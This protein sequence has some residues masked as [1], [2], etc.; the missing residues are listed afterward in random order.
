[1]NRMGD[2]AAMPGTA[3]WDAAARAG[4]PRAGRLRGPMERRAAAQQ[5]IDA[6]YQQA[7]VPRVGDYDNPAG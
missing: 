6:A 1:M 2:L 3:D 5:S 4:R 7:G